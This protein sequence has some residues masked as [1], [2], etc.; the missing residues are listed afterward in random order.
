MTQGQKLTTLRKQKNLTQLEVAELVHV[1]R[2]SI[3]KWEKGISVPSSENLIILSKIY[4]VSLDWLCSTDE[5]PVTDS[6]ALHTDSTV[7][8]FIPDPTPASDSEHRNTVHR[9]TVYKWLLI[10][11]LL[12]FLS[13]L[14]FLLYPHRHAAKSSPLSFSDLSEDQEDIPEEGSFEIG[15]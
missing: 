5:D 15:W 10:V 12:F 13:C 1:S 9:K 11:L 4:N 7:S 3:S 8:D 14:I 6:D 2:Q